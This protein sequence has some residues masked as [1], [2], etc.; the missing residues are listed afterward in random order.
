MPEFS[1]FIVYVDESGDA[2]MDRIDPSFPMLAL[3]FCI[4]SK[5]VYAC[6]II[7]EMQSFKFKYWGHDAIILHEHEIRKTFN[8]F[9]FL[10]RDKDARESF[11]TDLT[12]LVKQSVFHIIASVIDKQKLSERYPEPRCPYQL[13]LHF[14][15]ERLHEFLIC[16]KQDGKTVHVIFESRGPKED[17][18]L[19]LQFRRI[20][21]D[22]AHWGWRK[23]DFKTFDFQPVFVS[24]AAN[25]CGLQL[26]DL[27]ARPLALRALR[28]DQD[29]RSYNA[30]EEKLKSYKVFP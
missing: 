21:D 29:N 24:K 9:A 27:T 26:A 4:V 28:P 12:D 30:I 10:R 11:M 23:V 15:M 18:D 14:C 1:D 20:A 22:E 17:K 2:G 16:E 7:P 5:D 13:A 3:S 6:Q 25:A 8:D 19:E